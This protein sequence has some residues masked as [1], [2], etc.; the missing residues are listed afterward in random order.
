[1]LKT[2]I[3]NIII[4]LAMVTLSYVLFK[5][6]KICLSMALGSAIGGANFWALYKIITGL[7]GVEKGRFKFI[8]FAFLKFFTLL[9]VLWA[10]IKFLPLNAIAFL[11]GLSTIV[12][13]VLLTWLT[14]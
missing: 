11:I 13:A 7:V 8:V 5:D 1:M 9:F 6:T 14:H 2:E 3:I 12:I 4:M 10:S